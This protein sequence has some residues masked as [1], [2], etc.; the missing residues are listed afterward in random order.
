M[1]L[2]D[3]FYVLKD[4][5]QSDSTIKAKV[6]INS[7]HKVFD[8]H[9]PE[10]PVVPGV[11]MMEM[12]KEILEISREENY[13]LSSATNIKFMNILN[14]FVH[15]EVEFVHEIVSENTEEIKLKSSILYE[16]TVFL[17]FSGSF[18]KKTI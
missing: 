18:R 11:C 17:K 15:P 7:K 2:L 9:F 16:E 14:P 3:D 1:P 6:E 5:I 10:N 13:I 12:I 4:L 8:G